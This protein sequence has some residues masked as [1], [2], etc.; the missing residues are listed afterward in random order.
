MLSRYLFSSLVRANPQSHYYTSVTS[1][2]ASLRHSSNNL[3]SCDGQ[4]KYSRLYSQSPFLSGDD[5]PTAEVD[6]QKQKSRINRKTKKS[7]AN[8]WALPSIDSLTLGGTDSLQEIRA[9]SN[10][11]E[12]SVLTSSSKSQDESN[13]PAPASRKKTVAQNHQ[14]NAFLEG[15]LDEKARKI[16]ERK[17]E[18]RKRMEDLIL[19]DS[20]EGGRVP[21]GW[22]KN[23]Y[24]PEWKRQMYALREKFGNE[25]WQPQKKLSREAMDGIRALKEHS[26]DM[27][28]GDFAKMFKVSPESIRRIL[29][30]NWSPIE[31]EMD[32][33]TKRWVRRGERV[34]GALKVQ[35]RLEREEQQQ[36]VQARRKEQEFVRAAR[37]LPIKKKK[38]KK[39]P[40]GRS[41]NRKKED[42]DDDN[43]VH[44]VQSMIF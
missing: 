39:A 9:E 14:Q 2:L 22:R 28:A 42:D 41:S 6:N 43:E 33:I 34:K 11:T 15:N 3:W 18:L 5:E 21:K 35:A 26:P 29:R 23:R 7:K 17:P 20:N 16:L 25:K 24:L 32:N 44:G 4:P 19:E 38:K 13:I 10:V 8:S 37:G 27:N 40:N 12:A 30:S 1:Q 31:N 36:E